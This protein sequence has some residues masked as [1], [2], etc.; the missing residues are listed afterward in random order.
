MIYAHVESVNIFFLIDDILK[1]KRNNAVH[2]FERFAD[3]ESWLR[4]QW[5][6]LFRELLSRRSQQQQLAT[7][8]DQVAGLEEV[9]KTLK[10]Y[11]EELMRANS[12]VNTKDLIDDENRR[13]KE[14]SQLSELRKNNI[15][16]T[17]VDIFGVSFEDVVSSI[18]ESD[19]SKSL[20]YSL[21]KKRNGGGPATFFISSA[22]SS[23]LLKKDLIGAYECL[24]R[25][26]VD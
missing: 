14:L 26:F 5:A 9:N 23:E 13:L 4:E 10:K 6:G 16:K 21:S 24:G 17:L 18:N 22:L 15:V 25:Q 11:L 12:K 3:I 1:Q 19:S 7:L 2:T 20:M 8:S